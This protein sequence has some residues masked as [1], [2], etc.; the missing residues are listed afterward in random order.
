M[1]LETGSKTQ[2]YDF[3]RNEDE[4]FM[5]LHI[6]QG[7]SFLYDPNNHAH[8]TYITNSGCTL[9][10]TI[11]ETTNTPKL[12]TGCINWSNAVW[13]VN[14]NTDIQFQFS[15]RA[16]CHNKF[17]IVIFES[18]STIFDQGYISKSFVA[19][20]IM[21]FALMRSTLATIVHFQSSL[22]LCLHNRTSEAFNCGTFSSL[23]PRV[24]EYTV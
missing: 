13:V 1:I 2:F 9:T 17:I 21:W 19:S 7:I 16:Q 6:L 23:F 8:S 14:G 22:L 24:N 12:G 3:G 15:V 11:R 18:Y 5:A 4:D 20:E 10:N